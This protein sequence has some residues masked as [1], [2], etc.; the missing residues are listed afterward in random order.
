MSDTVQNGK[1]SKRRPSTV[2]AETFSDNWDAIFGDAKKKWSVCYD[3]GEVPYKK[4]F[5]TYAEAQA[6]YN[7]NKDYLNAELVLL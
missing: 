1:G 4:V 5:D 3:M 2:T 7:R 6:Y